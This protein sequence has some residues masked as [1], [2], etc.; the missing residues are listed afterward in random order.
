MGRAGAGRRSAGGGET[1][2]RLP[3]AWSGAMRLVRALP[4]VTAAGPEPG[5]GGGTPSESPVPG[6]A[7]RDDPRRPRG[8][9]GERG[10]AGGGRGARGPCGSSAAPELWE[11][12][13]GPGGRGGWRRRCRSHETTWASCGELG[14]TRRGQREVKNRHPGRFWGLAGPCAGKS[15]KLCKHAKCTTIPKSHS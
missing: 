3:G 7:L 9:P 10:G 4:A 11:R 8:A 2:S 12:P 6:G 1:R 13:V 5:G 15:W 14:C